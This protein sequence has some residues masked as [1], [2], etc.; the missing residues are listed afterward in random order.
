MGVGLTVLSSPLLNLQ[1]T[2]DDANPNKL[3]LG[4]GKTGFQSCFVTMGFH[5]LHCFGT[6][7]F[8]ATDRK[9][10]STSGFQHLATPTFLNLPEDNSLVY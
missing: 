6:F 2:E 7:S 3:R 1:C 4:L 9:R 10:Y 8:L 5:N